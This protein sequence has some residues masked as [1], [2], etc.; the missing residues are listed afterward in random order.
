MVTAVFRNRTNGERAFQML[1]GMGYADSD[2]NVVMTERT[3]TQFSSDLKEA[4]EME[5][6]AEGVAVG[7]AV[8]AALGATLG[9]VA[10]IGTTSIVLPG[11][12]WV[13]AGPL[14]WGLIG[15]AGGGVAGECVGALVGL[16]MSEEDATVYNKALQEGSVLLGVVP[17]SN[18]QGR[19][20]EK[21]FRSLGGED[22]RSCTC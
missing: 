12:G 10:A 11:L 9:A 18:E 6:T 7:G 21:E 2:I 17:R 15:G 13:I 16:G 14:A 4:D 22:V 19:R 1:H 5:R 20:I 8:G 3:R